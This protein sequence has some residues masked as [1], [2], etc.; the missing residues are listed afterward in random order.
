[1]FRELCSG[2]VQPRPHGADGHPE[3][4]GRR[5]VVEPRPHAQ[6]ED[7][8]LGTAQLVQGRLYEGQLRL[9]VDAAREVIGEVA[10]RLVARQPG[11]GRRVSSGGPAGVAGDVGGDAEQLGAQRALPVLDPLHSRQASRKVSDTTSSACAHSPVSRNA[12]L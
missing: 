10:Y 5:R 6:R 2:P 9:V 3:R 12:W 7:L 8:P 4:L 11:Y 1:M